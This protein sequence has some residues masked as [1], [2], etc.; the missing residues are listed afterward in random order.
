M[1]IRKPLLWLMVLPVTLLAATACGTTASD[2]PENYPS[3]DITIVVQAPAGGPSDLTARTAARIAEKKLDTNIIVEN[4]PGGAGSVAFQYVAQKPADGYTLA[5]IPIEVAMLQFL[6]YD[7]KP[8]DFEMIAQLAQVPT[9][10]TVKADSPY[11]TFEDFVEAAK[12]QPGELSVANSGA[13]GSYNVATAILEQEANIELNPV[14]F[15]GGGPAATAVRSGDVDAAT[16][17]TVE[18]LSGIESGNLKVLAVFDDKRDPQLPDTPTAKELG[19]DIEFLTLNGFAAPAG[20][21]EKIVGE[22]AAAFETTA[23]SDEFQK[24]M[25]NAGAQPVYRGPDEFTEYLQEQEDLLA[26]V[27]PTMKTEE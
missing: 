10:L 22:L 13:G 26:E 14:P 27:M 2:D 11:E 18:A 15:D 6:D 19:Y 8:K 1:N 20:T 17:G 21:P 3:E 9:N 7:I 24:T 5:H 25:Q 16:V 4:R 12:E 23:E